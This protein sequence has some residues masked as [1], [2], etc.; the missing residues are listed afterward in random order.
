MRMM[1]PPSW[2]PQSPTRVSNR[3]RKGGR[4]VMFL[5]VMYIGGIEPCIV[6]YF[7]VRVDQL[8]L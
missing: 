1:L 7:V 8:A 5:P 3:S 6:L 4:I 2:R